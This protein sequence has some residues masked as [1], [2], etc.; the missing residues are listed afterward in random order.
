MNGWIL[1]HLKPR[2]FSVVV[3]TYQRPANLRLVLL[4]LALQRD[5]PEG[6]EVVVTDDGSQDETG[7]VV[8]EFARTSDIPV[9]WTSHTHDGFQPSRTRNAGVRL[10]RGRYL[11]LLDGDCIVPHDHLVRHL[12]FR[13]PDLVALGDC[14]RLDEADSRRVT[15]GVVRSGEYRQWAPPLER[16]RLR[17]RHRQAW[18]YNV[19][20]HRRKP[21]LIGNNVGVWHADYVRVNGYDENYRGWG[22][23]DDDFGQRLRWAGL[24][25]RSILGQT[26]A[27]H[28]WHPT[29][30]SAPPRWSDGANVNYFL[31]RP[32]NAWCDNGLCKSPPCDSALASALR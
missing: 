25:L 2:D 6:F 10:A 30:P 4:S 24:R 28:L 16:K 7:D 1:P 3:C 5:L 26:W 14:C 15:D 31:S 17:K 11:L 29:D 9:A 23:E 18:Y 12:Q 22:C 8:A 27:Y 20:R 21:K 13:R 19:I 32:P